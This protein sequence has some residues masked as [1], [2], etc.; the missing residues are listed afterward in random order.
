MQTEW[1]LSIF[2][3]KFCRKYLAGIKKLMA[4]EELKLMKN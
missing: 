4:S 1:Q 2:K 3:G